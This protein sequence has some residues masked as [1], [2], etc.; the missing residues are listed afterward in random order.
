MTIRA[1]RFGVTILI[2]LG[3]HN[4]PITTTTI[5]INIITTTTI[6]ITKV[7][8]AITTITLILIRM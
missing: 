3:I 4:L 1:T 7:T 2:V 8:T 6:Y 5:T